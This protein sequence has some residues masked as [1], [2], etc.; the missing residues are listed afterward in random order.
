MRNLLKNR[1]DLNI[2]QLE[3]TKK[4]MNAHVRN[5]LVEDYE[6]FEKNLKL[7]DEDDKHVLAAAIKC[8]AQAIVTFNLKDFPVAELSKYDIEAISPDEFLLN[9]LD[10]NLALVCH[11][12]KQHRAALKN[13][14][15]SIADYL[16]TAI[17]AETEQKLI[18]S[19]DILEKAWAAKVG[20]S[21][22]WCSTSDAPFQGRTHLT[23]PSFPLFFVGNTQPRKL[24]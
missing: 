2:Q 8:N 20:G 21:F 5:S 7:P 4:L 9:Q 23:F 3:R 15:K 18:I 1:P 12:V 11:V 10:L 14:P 6:I 16:D 24:T 13:P 17:D 22:T 19:T